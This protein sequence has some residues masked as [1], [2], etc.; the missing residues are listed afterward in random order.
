MGYSLDTSAL[1]VPWNDHYQRR[2]FGGFWDRYEALIDCG[3]AVAVE[4]V[5]LE[6]EKRDDDLR[7]WARARRGMFLPLTADV[8]RALSDVLAFS[9]RMVG[10][11]KGRNAADPWVIALARARGL[12]VVTME[13]A[14]GNLTRP[15]IPDVCAALQV[16]CIDVLGLAVAEGWKF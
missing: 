1:M 15:K 2:V 9:Q 8:Q 14:N 5:L 11:Q 7:E 10:T 12:T 4:E 6:I 16:P 13:R 3:E